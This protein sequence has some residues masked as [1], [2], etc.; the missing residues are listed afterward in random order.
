[1]EGQDYQ[2]WTCCD[3]SDASKQEGGA[4]AADGAGRGGGAPPDGAGR[5]GGAPDG[6]GSGGGAPNGAGREGGAPD[7]A[8][9]GGGGGAPDGAGRGRGAGRTEE[10]EVR[11]V[12]GKVEWRR[13][14][15]QPRRFHPGIDI[16]DIIF[17]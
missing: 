16:H 10:I 12:G 5:G 4:G 6:V 17:G 7:G 11:T 2:S 13:R 1:M 14:S 8:G 15:L 3:A 9:G